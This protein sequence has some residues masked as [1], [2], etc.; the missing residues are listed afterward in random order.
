LALLLRSCPGE[1]IQGIDGAV[2]VQ[3]TNDTGVVWKGV[4]G[5]SS[6]GCLASKA[7]EGK[8]IA[9]GESLSVTLTITPSTRSGFKQNFELHGVVGDKPNTEL[10]AVVSIKA[11]VKPPVSVR[12][13]GFSLEDVGKKIQKSIVMSGATGRTEIVWD[14]ISLQSD[15]LEMRFEHSNSSFIGEAICSRRKE[16][17][18]DVL[19]DLNGN[20]VIPFRLA[21]KS[22]IYIS[23]T[24]IQFFVTKAL[25]VAPNAVNL[26]ATE[27]SDVF[28]IRLIVTDRRGQI[29]AAELVY[30]LVQ[31]NPHAAE[32]VLIPSIQDV[33]T[34]KSSEGA[35]SSLIVTQVS[36]P[37]KLLK[38]SS[39]D[40][41]LILRVIDAD[42]LSGKD[43]YQFVMADVQ[44]I[45]EQNR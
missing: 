4:T 6:C 21:G 8:S 31:K 32:T 14:Q 38:S 23:H 41:S 19:R 40:K 2:I 44:L 12:P 15:D 43:K 13:T 24:P 17:D 7:I 27:G 45:L 42:S 10:L 37:R 36:L 9:P 29:A 26:R 25:K 16:V 11:V 34:K 22:E 35:E 20:L 18:N 30:Q 1:Q 33:K 39:P 5:K 3:F 28:E